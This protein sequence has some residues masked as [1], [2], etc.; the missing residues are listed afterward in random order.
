MSKIV[1][2]KIMGIVKQQQ[3]Q[4]KTFKKWQHATKGKNV[5]RG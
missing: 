1:V 5:F 2:Q 4:Q 3:Q